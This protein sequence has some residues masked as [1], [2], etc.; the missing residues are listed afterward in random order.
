MP[1]LK[2]NGTKTIQSRIL[3]ILAENIS[4]RKIEI[5]ISGRKIESTQTKVN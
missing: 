4:G 1:A 2:C 5:Y 3:P